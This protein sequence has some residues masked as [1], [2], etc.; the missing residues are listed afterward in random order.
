VL[1]DLERLRQPAAHQGPAQTWSGSRPL[2]KP[3]LWLSNIRSAVVLVALAAAVLLPSLTIS[4]RL[5]DMRLEQLLLP[6]AL[7]IFWIDWRRGIRF[8]FGLLD[9][10]FAGLALSTLV[11]ITV[12]PLILRTSMSPRDFYELLKLALYYAI[13]RLAMS[14]ATPQSGP[15]AEG[16]RDEMRLA[17]SIA[18]DSGLQRRM[19]QVFLVAGSI[20]AAL[21]VAQYFDWLRVNSW[22]SGRYAPDL[23]LNVLRS[24][25]RVVGTVANPNYFGILCAMVAVAALLCFWLPRAVTSEGK[26]S[27]LQERLSDGLLAIAGLLAS[28]GIVMSGSRTALLALGAGLVAIFAYALVCRMSAG[29]VRLLGGMAAVFLFIALAVTVV[30]AFPRGQVDYVGRVGGL[31]A[32]DDAS[33]GLRIARWRSILDSWLFRPTTALTA[34]AHNARTSVHATGVQPAST[35]VIARDDKRKAD[36]LSVAGAIDAYHRDTGSWH[37]PYELNADLVPRYLAAMPADPL[38]GD[39]YTDI[40]TVTGYS[41]LARL[42]NP[43]DPD[44]PTYAMG[45]SPN[46]LENGDFARGGSHP[47][48]WDT[49]SGTSIGAESRDALYGSRAVVY[50]G[51]QG[52][53]QQRTAIYQQRYFGRPGGNPF[54]ASAWVKLLPGASGSLELY[55]NVIYADGQR[56]DPLTRVPADMSKTG[57][58]QRVSLWMLPPAGTN[59]AYVGVYLLSDDFRGQALLDGME[60]VDGPIPLSFAITQEAPPSDTFGF[61]PDAKL[62]QSPIIGVGPEKAVSGSAIDDEYLLYA[63]RYGLVGLALYLALYLGTLV[64]CVRESID[65]SSIFLPLCLLV[66]T[67]V[68]ML[69]VFNITAGSFYELQIMAIFW[70]LAGGALAGIGYR[71]VS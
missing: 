30:E 40:A 42:E 2:W 18:E 24:S 12:S 37:K 51:P 3:F 64:L 6:Y 58:W 9:W 14:A 13:F 39:A 63:A 7:I 59:V 47:S 19:L 53:V 71:G 23:H 10:V 46:Y 25:G 36:L 38:S 22:L 65:R 15:L 5:P 50:G 62:R 48:G 31:T 60:L 56:A 27:A 45:S 49:I 67:T 21:G 29:I 17:I 66:A 1:T 20:G 68:V 41:L 33:L 11:S 8:R 44:Y 70:I 57:V 26:R 69:L 4:A 35:A 61:N 32:G 54:T 28:F 16:E 55:T 52:N 34:G 43:A